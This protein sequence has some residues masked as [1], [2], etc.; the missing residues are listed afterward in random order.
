MPHALNPF[1]YHQGSS[2]VKDISVGFVGARYPEWICDSERNNFLDFYNENIVDKNKQIGIGVRK[3]T[4][5]LWSDFLRRCDGTIGAEA[6]TYYLDRE[7]EILRFAKNL[8]LSKCFSKQKVMEFIKTREFRYVNGKAV[9]SRHFEPIGTKTVQI[10]L[11]GF[12]N[13]ILQPDVHYLSV[14]RDL[15]N[16]SEKIREFDDPQR[17]NEI[18]NITYEYVMDCHTYAH[19]I[20]HFKSKVLGC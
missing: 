16:L 4:R 10:L 6:G 14:K 17:R 20:A 8:S 12:Y 11:E 19:R 2:T 13:G 1:V 15:S 3:L 5:T 18:A 7:G 9:S